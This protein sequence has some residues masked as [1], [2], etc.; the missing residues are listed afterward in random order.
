VIEKPALTS[1][2]YNVVV[3]VTCSV[4]GTVFD[5]LGYVHPYMTVAHNGMN[6]STVLRDY[7]VSP[8]YNCAYSFGGGWW[9]TFC[10]LWGP[11][12]VSPVWYSMGDFLWYYMK[13]IH[14]M[15]KPQ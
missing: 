15:V 10:A 4:A 7:D 5:F 9:H 12:T 2:L 14:M 11:T 8:L 6:F 13:E 3:D 1:L